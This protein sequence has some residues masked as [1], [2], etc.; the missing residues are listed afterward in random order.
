FKE[1]ALA[2]EQRWPYDSA[3][4][5][6][7]A[8]LQAPPPQRSCLEANRQ[9]HSQARNRKPMLIQISRDERRAQGHHRDD[10]EEEGEPHPVEEEPERREEKGHPRETLADENH[11]LSALYRLL[12]RIGRLVDQIRLH[13][14]LPVL[15]A[16]RLTRG[17]ELAA[18]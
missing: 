15:L 11:P 2:L 4:H 1:T 6:P 18:S 16:Q 14:A 8:P 5:A 10:V 13:C 3:Q 7:P 17:S 9:V 12:G